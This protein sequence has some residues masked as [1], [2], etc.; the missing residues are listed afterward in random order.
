MRVGA[1]WEK[2]NNNIKLFRE[3]S[4]SNKKNWILHIPCNI[5]ATTLKNNNLFKL[6]NWCLENNIEIKFYKVNGITKYDFENEDYFQ[7]PKLINKIGKNKF[8]TQFEKT[9]DLLK[10]YQKH[11][12][13]DNLNEIYKLS[14]IS[15]EKIS[16]SYKV[17]ENK[18]KLKRNIANLKLIFYSSLRKFYSK[19]IPKEIRYKIGKL[20]RKI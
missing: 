18:I 1:K 5:M 12:T 10:Q 20:R 8:N 2:I 17:D 4:I 9:L 15:E 13:S 16:F 7:N 14:K 11:S 6:T 19:I 3:Y